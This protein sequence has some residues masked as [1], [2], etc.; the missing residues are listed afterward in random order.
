M[1]VRRIRFPRTNAYLVDTGTHRILV[2]SGLGSGAQ[3]VRNALAR[4]DRAGE[5]PALLLLTHTHYDH[6]GNAAMIREE[7]GTPVLV[8]AAG[9][10]A[11]VR[12]YSAFPAGATALGRF[13]AGAAR[14]FGTHGSRLRAC[15]PDIVVGKPDDSATETTPRSFDLHEHGFPGVAVHVPCHSSDSLAFIADDGTCFC[16]DVMF[17]V[18]PGSLMPPFADSPERLDLHWRVLLSFGARVLYPGH[19]G[20]VAREWLERAVARER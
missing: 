14:A 20:P 8:H 10:D 16:G 11:L 4:G 2:D 19:G 9:R 7:Y 6:A 15:E 1:D 13:V 17:N 18:F 3:R 5:A 12:G